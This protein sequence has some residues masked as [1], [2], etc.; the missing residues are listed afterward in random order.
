L[1][2]GDYIQWLDADDLLA[3]DK[4]TRQLVD[5]EPGQSS[6]VLLSGAWGKFYDQPEAAR[7]EPSPL[8]EDL[9]PIEWLLRK[10]E[11]NLWMAIESWLVSRRLTE[12]AGPWD[13]SMSLDDDGEYFCR[14]LLCSSRVKFIPD[15]RSY[16][17]VSHFSM[18]NP[19]TLNGRKL[20]SLLVST[21]SYVKRMRAI[22]DSQR[23]RNVSLKLL[24]RWSFYFYPERPD[25]MQQLQLMA[26][27]IGGELQSPELRAKYRWIQKI[28]GWRIAKK[29]QHIFPIVKFNIKKHLKRIS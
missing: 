18:S 1:A 28:L 6:R 25:L 26:K 14:V 16:C 29:A 10:L 11:Y 21:L 12:M 4:I 8:W 7:F 13:E 20:E 17:R 23:T 2:Q 5:A 27:E 3:P 19:L 24:N 22:E 9:E 15:S